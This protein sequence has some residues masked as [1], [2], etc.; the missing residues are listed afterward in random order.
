MKL[1]ELR[2]YEKSMSIAEDVWQQVATW[3][4][5]QRDTVGKQWVRCA[6]SIA[7]NISEGYGRYH[8]KENKQFLYYARGSMFETQTWLEKAKKRDLVSKE[9]ALKMEADLDVLTPMLNRYI[10]SIG[11]SSLVKEDEP[12]YLCDS[13]PLTN[14]Q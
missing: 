11:G 3:P 10:Q 14:D 2:V 6:D 1:H 4:Y 13:F 12:D 7:A 8:F 9:F 5:F